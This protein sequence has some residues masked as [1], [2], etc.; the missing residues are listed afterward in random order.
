MFDFKLGYVASNMFEDTN[1]PVLL[2]VVNANWKV[3]INMY[4]QLLKRDTREDL[5]FS[6]YSMTLN[7]LG[8]HMGANGG[9]ANAIRSTLGLAAVTKDHINSQSL[10]YVDVVFQKNYELLSSKFFYFDDSI[11]LLK[12]YTDGVRAFFLQAVN[13]EFLDP[14]VA[15]AKI[16]Q[17][18]SKDTNGKM[19]HHVLK[20]WLTSDTK[21][22]IISALDFKGKWEVQFDSVTQGQF[23]TVDGA[24]KPQTY[25]EKTGVF[26]I[27]SIP[28]LSLRILE[29]PYFNN[30]LA[31]YIFLPNDHIGLTA[32]ETSRLDTKTLKD[33]IAALKPMN[34]KISI[35]KFKA[36]S[37]QELN[38][39][40]EAI[41]LGNLF[42]PGEADFSG[43]DSNAVAGKLALNQY[44][45]QAGVSF[46]VDGANS[47]S[48]ETPI[49]PGTT[50]EFKADHSFL[51]VIIGK[52]KNV[53]FFIG[54]YNGK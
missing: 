19:S 38:S 10:I 7:L 13:I 49:N 4:K 20:E 44:V 45:H 30:T 29:V 14:V 27:G 40:F 39:E 12:S 16:N 1:A 5:F 53:P 25:M 24:F 15:A 17:N 33:L 37:H 18:V 8:L 11:N 31:K 47:P 3:A 34:A 23:K 36:L 43:M 48:K 6:P 35:P 52:K 26:K 51:Y 42:T 41:G 22:L 9:T 54:R 32:F 21:F 50:E 28:N 46:D 2:E